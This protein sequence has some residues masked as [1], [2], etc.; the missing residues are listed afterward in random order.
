ME[1]VLVEG[2]G[3]GTLRRNVDERRCVRLLYE[4]HRD[5]FVSR[6]HNLVQIIPTIQKVHL[7]ESYI[8]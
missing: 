1:E 7:A 5:R 3:W 4:E 8:V 6:L 2:L